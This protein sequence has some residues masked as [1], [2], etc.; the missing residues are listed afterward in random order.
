MLFL[1]Y[2]TVYCTSHLVGVQRAFSSLLSSGQVAFGK[3]QQTKSIV[4]FLF[5]AGGPGSKYQFLNKYC[6]V[7]SQSGRAYNISKYSR[8][9]YRYCTCFDSNKILYHLET[10]V[11]YTLKLSYKILSN[12]IF[13]YS[14]LIWFFKICEKSTAVCNFNLYALF[15]Y[16]YY[17]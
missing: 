15:T 10:V 12:N 9:S 2:C 14:L 16:S 6:V 4:V 5:R 17:N 11:Y 7:Q 13:Q 1:S 3:V 8:V